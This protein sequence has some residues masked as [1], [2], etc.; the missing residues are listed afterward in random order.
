MSCAGHDE[1]GETT[2]VVPPRFTVNMGVQLIWQRAAL[3][4]LISQ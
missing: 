1:V 3:A 2:S 4:P